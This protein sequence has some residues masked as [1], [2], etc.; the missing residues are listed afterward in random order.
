MVQGRERR[1]LLLRWDS[2]PLYACVSFLFSPF[3]YATTQWGHAPFPTPPTC[4]EGRRL[5][6][7]G[8]FTYFL[9]QSITFTRCR[10]VSMC[11]QRQNYTSQQPLGPPEH[12]FHAATRELKTE[13]SLGLGISGFD[14]CSSA[15]CLSLFLCARGFYV[16]FVNNYWT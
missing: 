6:F 10:E 14:S 13:L 5:W 1:K 7:G 15:F 12:L 11:T 4:R 2:L 8:C 16:Y 9:P 3:P